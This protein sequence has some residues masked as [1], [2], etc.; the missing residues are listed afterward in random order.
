MVPALQF[1]GWQ[2]LSFA[3]ATPVVAYGGWPFHRAAWTNLRHGAATMDTLVSL[4][5][6]AAFGWSVWALLAPPR[7]VPGDRGRGHHVHPARPLPGGPGQA[8]G[9]AALRALLE[10]GAKD[11]AVLRDGRE[12]RIPVGAARA[13][14]TGSWS[15]PARR[16]PP[17]AI[18]LE[19]SSAVDAS[20]LTGESVPVEVGPGDRG[21]RRHRE[22]RRP[23]GGRGDPRRRGH[24][25]GPDGP[26]GRA[27]PE[28]QGRRAAA[29]RPDLRR[30]R[31]GR[32]SS[33]PCS[34]SSA[35]CSSAAARPRRSPPR[36]PC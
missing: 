26:P 21:H 27:G 33:S 16:S 12:Q 5:T 31:A 30:L 18:V 14:A 19:G 7:H 36:S 34:P 24:P 10:L 8:A 17:T 4:G 11:V 25:A 13:S 6:L 3:L 2:W 20:M 28:R 1:R 29:G 22:R 35:G 32:S 23:A 15:G 9:R